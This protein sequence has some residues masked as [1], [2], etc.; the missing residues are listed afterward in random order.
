MAIAPRVVEG[1]PVS[2]VDG[3]GNRREV[4]LLSLNGTV[5]A[6]TALVKKKEGWEALRDDPEQ[7]VE[8]LGKIGVPSVREGA[9]KTA[10]QL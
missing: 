5:L 6:G 9:G 1:T 4:G 2:V 3:E 10:A 7:L 8:L